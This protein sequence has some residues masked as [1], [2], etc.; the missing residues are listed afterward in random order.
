VVSELDFVVGS[1]SNPESKQEFLFLSSFMPRV[2][3]CY[4]FSYLCILVVYS[5]SSSP[6]RDQYTIN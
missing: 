1:S 6:T 3:L 4:Y 2:V 5:A